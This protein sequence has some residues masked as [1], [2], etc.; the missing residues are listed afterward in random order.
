MG[1]AAGMVGAGLIAARAAL[2]AGAGKVWLASLDPAAPRVDPLQ[3]E[4]MFA[5]AAEQGGDDETWVVGP[6]LGDSTSA[7]AVLARA[8]THP[9]PLLLDADALNLLAAEHDW[10]D[11]LATRSGATVLTPHPAEAARLLGCS[12]SAVQADRFNA[13]TR[14]AQRSHAVVVLKGAGTLVAWQAQLA[15]NRSGSAALA[16]AGQGD[17]LSGLIGG[18]LA[19]GL[20]AWVAANLGVWAHGAASDACVAREG[21]L[22]TPATTL[23]PTLNALLG[24]WHATHGPWQGSSS[25]RC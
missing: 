1:A 6:G 19:Q 23:L 9:G 13:V 24:R 5:D 21:W 18:L 8:F 17:L 16:N 4:L 11:R 3:A 20:P 14:L 10:T 15:I 25:R 22:T 2:H 7:H 12:T